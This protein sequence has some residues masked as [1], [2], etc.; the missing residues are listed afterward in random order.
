MFRGREVGGGGVKLSKSTKNW[1][2]GFNSIIR[3]FLVKDKR[4]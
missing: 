1:G 2:V 3:E 4:G